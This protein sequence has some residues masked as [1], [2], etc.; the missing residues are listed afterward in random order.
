[1]RAE[2]LGGPSRLGGPSLARIGGSPRLLQ[3]APQAT[4]PKLA[5]GV[6]SQEVVHQ[7]FPPKRSKSLHNASAK[8]LKLHPPL[9]R[10]SQP[11]ECLNER[12]VGREVSIGRHVTSEGARGSS[13]SL[14]N[15]PLQACRLGACSGTL[16]NLAGS[17]TA[18]HSVQALLLQQQVHQGCHLTS[19]M[20]QTRLLGVEGPRI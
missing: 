3:V 20:S 4:T 1:M 6:F 2:F 10:S 12:H 9:S 19:I 14:G 11:L 7:F 17:L 8:E 18:R 5:N 13:A 15:G 16:G